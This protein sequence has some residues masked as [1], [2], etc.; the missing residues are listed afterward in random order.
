MSNF[1]LIKKNPTQGEI[2]SSLTGSTGDGAGL[3]LEAGGTIT[4]TNAAAAE[5]GTSDFSLEFVLN[6]TANNTNNNVIYESHSS[7]N[8]R[9]TLKAL[10][11]GDL[12]ATFTNSSGV[13][14]DYNTGYD[15]DVDLNTVTHY[16]LTFD[17]SGDLTVYKNGNSVATISIAASSAVDIGASNTNTGRIGYV[18]TYGV[19][20]TF[21]R[22]RAFNTLADAKLL[23]ERADVPQTLTANLLFDLDLAFANPSQSLTVQDRKGNTD[24]S[25][26]SSTAVSQVQP[27]IQGNMRSLAVTTTSQAAG[28]PAD[29]ELIANS[30]KVGSGDVSPDGSPTLLV[31]DTSAGGSVIVRGK[32]PILAF[33]KTSSGTATILTDGGGLNVKDGTL[34][35]HGSTHLAISSTGQVGLSATPNL[36]S[37]NANNTILT[38]KGKAAAYGGIIEMSNHGT[39]GNGQT[40]GAIS[41]FDPST[42]TTKNAEIEV[43]RESADDDAKMVFKTKPTG[44]TLADR[45]TI[46]STGAVDI[47]GATSITEPDGRSTLTLVGAK[48][49]D[50]NYGDILGSNNDAAGRAQISFRRDSQ[51]DATAIL[52]YTEPTGGSMTERL[53]VSSAG[54]I[55][56]TNATGS[57]PVLTLENTANDANSSNLIFTKN[58]TATNDDILG[59]VR[60]KGNNN[61]GTPEVIEYATIYAQSSTVTDGAED[62]KLIIRTMK[63]GT[64]AAR[65]TIAS[66]GVAEFSNGINLGDTTLSNYAEGTWTP[67]LPNGGT[68]Q[69]NSGTYTRIGNICHLQFYVSSIAPTADTSQF[70]IGGFPFTVSDDA[71]YFAAG[72]IG[73][74]GDGQFAN[75]RLVGNNNTTTCYFHTV[76]GSSATLTNNDFISQFSG[77]S[78][79]LVCS[80]T[81]RVK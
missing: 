6:R 24:G 30:L 61:A 18:T 1:T 21:Y 62:G 23:F 66:D 9:I 40:L 5:F 11:G 54:D 79:A 7:G 45:L 17:R 8:N 63:D 13:N 20:G 70:R 80:I 68:L 29:G 64:L 16:A 46:S 12:V 2:T 27:I 73:Y 74:A 44:G 32:S 59:T 37:S 41:Y 28:V 72:S 26:S 3:H 49:S 15:I 52:F 22:F 71:N 60:F 34:D 69:T 65:L 57:K 38:L 14:A 25:A 76:A 42:A 81:Y 4:L 53:R 58:R 51:D 50:G 48:T 43:L 36:G 78:D 77:S 19:I 31:T 47:A 10:T 67:T 35:S 56:S 55:T 75:Y 33:D 39:S